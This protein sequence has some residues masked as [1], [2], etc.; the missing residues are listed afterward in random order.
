MPV[1]KRLSIE[2]NLYY[3]CPQKVPETLN[4]TSMMFNTTCKNKKF[5]TRIP[6]ALILSKS[7]RALLLLAWATQTH[8]R[9]LM[10]RIITVKPF[11]K[12]SRSFSITEIFLKWNPPPPFPPS[13]SVRSFVFT[14]HIR[15]SQ[16]QGAQALI[17]SSHGRRPDWV[18]PAWVKPDQYS[19]V[20]TALHPSQ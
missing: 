6:V 8:A 14:I 20:G 4:G 18:L 1:C 10:L 11:L 3:P 15:Y 19:P 13:Q 5:V 12:H 7:T 16:L 2:Y 9:S 17:I